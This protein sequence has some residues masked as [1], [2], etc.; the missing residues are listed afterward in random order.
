MKHSERVE[1]F[2]DRLNEI[3]SRNDMSRSAM[4]REIGIDRSTLSQLL[5]DHNNRL[6]RAE[7]IAT[8]A[9]VHQVSADWLLG[10]SQEGSLGTDLMAQPME[11]EQASPSE[12]DTLLERWHQEAV[13]YKI[14]Y[15]PSTLPDL[16]KT[17]PVL[18]YE[19]RKLDRPDPDQLI[20]ETEQRLTYQRRPETE[21]EA[22]HS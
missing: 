9:E 4:A 1:I 16:L 3:L 22:C 15:V 5:S 14:R 11:F 17:E 12:L 21:M 6:P 19:F 10:L 7:T 13:G 8:I 20:E 18:L 2:R